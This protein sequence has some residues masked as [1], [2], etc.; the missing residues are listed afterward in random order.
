MVDGESDVLPA[1]AGLDASEG[2][3]SISTDPLH[4]ISQSRPSRPCHDDGW[5]DKDHYFENDDP[6]DTCDYD[7]WKEK[8]KDIDEIQVNGAIRKQ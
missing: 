1:A 3:A 2:D 4:S 5:L 6:A 7:K 8:Y